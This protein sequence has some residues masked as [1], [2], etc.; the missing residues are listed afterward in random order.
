MPKIHAADI[1][2]FLP[3]Q[4]K[5]EPEEEGNEVGSLLEILTQ[6]KITLYAPN[7]PKSKRRIL[8][9]W[10]DK[11]KVVE[12]PKKHMDAF[13]TPPREVLTEKYM[14]WKDKN[15]T[16]NKTEEER[17]KSGALSRV[18]GYILMYTRLTIL[19]PSVMERTGQE[20]V[21]QTS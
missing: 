20:S 8:D 11:S 2:Q 14:G 9:D 18:Y 12:T 21:E 4:V 6:K 16:D 1:S 3:V 15:F 7:Q 5:D 13:V 19:L 10:F 17:R